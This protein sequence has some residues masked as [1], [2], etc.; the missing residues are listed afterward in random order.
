MKLIKAATIIAFTALI[1]ACGHGFE[2]E[3]ES[4][5]KSGNDMANALLGAMGTQKITIGSDYIESQGQRKKMDDIFVRNSGESKYLVFKSG[6]SEEAM[7]IVDS[8]TLE[9]DAGF[10]K[11]QFVR[12]K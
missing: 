1:T 3:F 4:K 2:G 5:V 10:V 9:Q 7:K 8:D 6:E 11:V 12:I